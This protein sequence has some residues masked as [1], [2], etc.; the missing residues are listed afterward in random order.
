[1]GNSGSSGGP[2]LHIQFMDGPDFLSASGLPVE[3][4]LEGEIYDPQCGEIVAS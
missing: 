3:F 1:L 4:D 2:H